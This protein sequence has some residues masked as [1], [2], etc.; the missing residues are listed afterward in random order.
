M[1]E[2]ELQFSTVR[3][4]LLSEFGFKLA[5]PRREGH[6]TLFCT[7]SVPAIVPPNTFGD[8]YLSELQ[9][10]ETDLAKVGLTRVKHKWSF[11]PVS[12]VE[13][14]VVAR[15]DPRLYSID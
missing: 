7:R 2:F 6:W 12:T 10:I 1:T 11:R 14:V 4:R 3:Q 9:K 5:T 8:W 15:G 13:I